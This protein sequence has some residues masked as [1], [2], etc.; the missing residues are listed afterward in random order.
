M[1][2]G[3]L[4]PP[5]PCGHQPLKL[6]TVSEFFAV[7]VPLAIGVVWAGLTVRRLRRAEVA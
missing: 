2:E 3:G 4:E 5:R 6:G 1:S 7:A